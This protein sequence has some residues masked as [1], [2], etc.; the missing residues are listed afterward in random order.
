MQIGSGRTLLNACL[1]RKSKRTSRHCSLF[2]CILLSIVGLG[3][4]QKKT[5]IYRSLSH[6]YCQNLL[7]PCL[8]DDTPCLPDIDQAMQRHFASVQK[9]FSMLLTYHP[10][11]D[12]EHGRYLVMNDLLSARIFHGTGSQLMWYL[13]VL[14][15]AYALNLTLVHLEWTAEHADDESNA[16]RE[17]FWQFFDWEIP[18]AAY[19]ACPANSSVKRNR[20]VY[21][22]V[23][24]QT[25]DQ[26]HQGKQPFTIKPS[27]QAL[28]ERFLATLGSDA[29]F[30]FYSPKT[31]TITSSLMEVG[32]VFE[33]RWWLQHRKL[34]NKRPGI[35]TG[36]PVLSDPHQPTDYF[37]YITSKTEPSRIMQCSAVNTH[38]V[39][40]IGVH[41]RQGD[42]VK[43]DDFGQII[44]GDLYRY[45]AHSAYAPLLISIVSGLPTHL[46]DK[47]LITIFSEGSVRDFHEILNGLKNALPNSRCRLVFFLN[48]RTSETFNRLLRQDVIIGAYSTFSMATGIFN[49]RQLKIGP[50]H[51][52]ARVHGMRNHLR[53][54]L[55]RNHTQFRLTDKRVQL[56]QQRI[57][58]AWLKKQRQQYSSIPLWLENYSADYPEE[59]M[60]I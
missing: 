26:H 49:S 15:V 44:H 11:I 24:K 31:F 12:C 38:D 47:Y 28:F 54:E 36:V 1:R 29:G 14:N 57:E 27:F 17:E 8:L 50:L 35:W 53:L 55:D 39:L 46:Q 5:S 40:S 3:F 32:V 13:G 58:D 52:Q 30:T 2:L 43:R 41:I 22:L 4:V 6:T 23:A 19:R 34:Y 60:L 7:D 10:T 25:F 59:F 51:N 16:D 21:D 20:F 33:T 37:Q 42:V 9:R 56:I 45:I 18:Y 48:E